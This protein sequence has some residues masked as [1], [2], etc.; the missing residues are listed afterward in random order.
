MKFRV[1][2][3]HNKKDKRI[4]EKVGGY[5]LS[6]NIDVWF[7]KWDIYA[8]DSLSDGVADGIVKSNV[9]LLIASKNSMKSNWVHEELRVALSRRRTAEDFKIITL[10]IEDCDLHPFLNDYAYIDYKNPRHFNR[11]MNELVNSILQIPKKPEPTKFKSKF[12]L[13]ELKYHIHFTEERGATTYV[14]EGYDITIL[15]NMPSIKKYLYNTG[16]LLEK[17][18]VPL[19]PGLS[20]K[21]NVIEETTAI[22]R[23]EIIFDKPLI[24]DK[25]Y[26]FTFNHLVKGNFPQDDEFFYYNIESETKKVIFSIKFDH[27]CMVK[28]MRV[29]QRTGQEEVPIKALRGK[30]NFNFIDYLPDLY[31]A[32]VFRWSWI[33]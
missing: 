18:F 2:I 13:D 25:N 27:I 15:K 3:S 21:I 28:N 8:G 5:L 1:F 11:V 12:V 29:F 32:Y 9:F 10:V 22:E 30:R 24:K 17:R 23:I 14:A 4:A 26:K 20:A 7:D 16:G 6:K 31:T 19:T 33:K